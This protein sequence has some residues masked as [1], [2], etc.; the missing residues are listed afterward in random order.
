MSDILRREPSPRRILKMILPMDLTSES[1]EISH[2][3]SSSP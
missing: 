1:H 3:H 2:T